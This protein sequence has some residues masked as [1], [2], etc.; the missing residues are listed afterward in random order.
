MIRIRDLIRRDS[1][2]ADLKAADKFEALRVVARF[3]C[4]VNGLDCAEA[5]ISNIA[6]REGEMSTGI[7][8]GIAIPHARLGGIDRL[9]MAAARSAEGIEFDSIDGFAVNLLFML[10]SPASSPDAHTEALS[11]LS[12]MLSDAE[13]RRGL[14]RAA[15]A[16]E[17]WDILARAGDERG[18]AP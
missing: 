4:S 9:Y 10:F 5:A 13:V 18:G 14:S 1:I 8:C 6:E 3:I 15:T 16:D 7:G 2:I 17:F 12:N 11:S